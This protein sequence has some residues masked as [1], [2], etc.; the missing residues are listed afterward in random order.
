M[1]PKTGH[2]ENVHGQHDSRIEYFTIVGQSYLKKL[3]KH[4]LTAKKK[5]ENG[6]KVLVLP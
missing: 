4:M 6:D 3:K 1:S 2:S 5:L